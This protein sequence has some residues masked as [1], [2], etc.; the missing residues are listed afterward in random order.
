MKH[1]LERCNKKCDLCSRRGSRILWQ[2][3]RS[4]FRCI[5][6]MAVMLAQ[7]PLGVLADR[8]GGIPVMQSSLLLWTIV[9]GITSLIRNLPQPQRFPAL[10]AARAALGLAQSCIMPA[11][12]AMAAK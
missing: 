7:I 9:T 10:L 6:H 12:S 2:S 11:T 3:A 5:Q 1:C 8:I 4:T